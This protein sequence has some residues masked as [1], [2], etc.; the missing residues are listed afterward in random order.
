MKCLFA[1]GEMKWNGV[2]GM[3]KV[4]HNARLE[5]GRLVNLHINDDRIEAITE[6][7]KPSLL[8]ENGIDLD[9]WLVIPSMAEPHA[10][11][12]KALTAESV[13]NPAG[14]LS[15]AIEAWIAATASGVI[16]YEDTVDRAVEAMRLL[17]SKGVT[18]VRSHV[19]VASGSRALE[20]VREARKIV[21]DLIDVQ[22]VAL[23]INPMT[24]PEGTDNR[25]AL[26]TAIETGVD[27]VGGCPHLDPNPSVLIKD[28]LGIAEDAGIGIDLHVD[29]MLDESVLT[30]HDLAKQVMD[31]GFE[32]SVTAS[33][34][35]TLGMQSLRK[36]AEVSADVAKANIAVLPL[37]QTNLFLQGRDISTATPRALTAIKSLEAAGV[38]VAAGADNVQDPFNLVGRSDPLETASL[39]ILAAHEMPENAY[40]MVSVNARKAMGLEKA[41]LSLGSLADFVAIDAPSLRGAIADAP[42]SRKVFKGGVLISSSLQTTQISPDG[43]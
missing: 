20:A 36:Q 11:L 5:D 14:D 35:V 34:C 39:L 38:L 19:N 9:G 40:K 15:G 42:M 43:L 18:A 1:H 29:E 27:L 24:G 2:I 17:V 6:L 4:L 12:D 28:A 10:H 23:T 21:A 16:T 41:D 32:N 7:Q 13:P 25:K 33:H 22:I 26:E 31:R 30:L 37:P 8:S 3:L